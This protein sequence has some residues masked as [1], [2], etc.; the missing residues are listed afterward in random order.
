MS[1]TDTIFALASGRGRA[2]VAVIRV[3]GPAAVSVAEVLAGSCPPP[4]RAA[5]RQLRQG[6][7]NSLLDEGIII[8]FQSTR[9][10]TG[11]DVVE[12]HVH[13]GPAV[14]TAVLAAIAQVPGT[15]LAEAGEFTRRAFDNG[16]LD[17]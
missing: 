16:R 9:S 11:E 4:R 5:L 6:P 15:R 7:D 8:Y 10:F 3:S 2:G 12:L 14:V 13:G 17:L 1:A